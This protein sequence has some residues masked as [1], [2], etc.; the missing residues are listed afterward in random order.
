MLCALSEAMM[1]SPGCMGIAHKR[2]RQ[3]KQCN[4]CGMRAQDE[5]TS[6]LHGCAKAV[7][8]RMLEALSCSMTY[9]SLSVVAH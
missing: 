6:L 5:Y 2:H 8:A 3:S 1:S 7:A 4:M 9:S